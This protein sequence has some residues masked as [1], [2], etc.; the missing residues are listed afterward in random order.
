MT[1]APLPSIGTDDFDKRLN[2][3]VDRWMHEWRG[4]YERYAVAALDLGN[5]PG[6]HVT[7]A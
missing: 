4:I 3:I 5:H 6:R 1:V 2:K 7:H